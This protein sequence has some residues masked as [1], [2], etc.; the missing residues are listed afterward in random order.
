M[1]KKESSIE[2]SKM[3]SEL[4]DPDVKR[5]TLSRFADLNEEE[6]KIYMIAMEKQP[7]QKKVVEN[8]APIGIIKPKD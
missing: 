4:E 1:E 6:R 3:L 7:E 8:I 2:L 5:P